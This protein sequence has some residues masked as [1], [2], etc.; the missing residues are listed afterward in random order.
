MSESNK[1]FKVKCSMSEHLTHAKIRKRDARIFAI[2]KKRIVK[3]DKIMTTNTNTNTSV[4]SVSVSDL[5]ETFLRTRTLNKRDKL[6]ATS[7]CSLAI[8]AV[9]LSQTQE[10]SVYKVATF[11][12][13][14]LRVTDCFHKREFANKSVYN[15]YKAMSAN[16][17][18]SHED[19][20]LAVIRATS[21]RLRNHVKDCCI[22]YDNF[23]TY[24]TIE[25][26][27]LLISDKLIKTCQ[28]A[29]KHI[30]A[31]MKAVRDS[32]FLSDA[33]KAKIESKKVT[34]KAADKKAKKFSKV[35][36]QARVDYAR[37]FKARKSII[38]KADEKKISNITA[39]HIR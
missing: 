11:L 14:Q 32:Q 4:S 1:N 22:A 19:R 2:H 18:L 25:D 20:T 27:K 29:S 36:E 37:E 28:K 38:T 16:D 23:N 12:V 26:D 15:E 31:M 10:T 39:L 7:K 24:V 9:A 34:K 13:K 35:S 33:T 5:A 17:V 6:T 8:S 3:R 21:N 30:N